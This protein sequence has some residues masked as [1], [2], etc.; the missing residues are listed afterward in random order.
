MDR[1]NVAKTING[2]DKTIANIK[3]TK[4]AVT[5][6]FDKDSNDVDV[7]HVVNTYSKQFPQR[8][9]KFNKR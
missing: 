4:N 6:V 9:L 8:E 5:I 1:I 3:L 7:T 2:K